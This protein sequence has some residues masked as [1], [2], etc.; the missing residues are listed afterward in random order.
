[1]RFLRKSK[2]NLP[3]RFN[4]QQRLFQG[5]PGNHHRSIQ[6]FRISMSSWILPTERKCQP[7]RDMY[8]KFDIRSWRFGMY[9]LY[10]GFWT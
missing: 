7:L 1:M 10:D 2:T 4:F 6:M 8:W 5:C 3:S 9:D